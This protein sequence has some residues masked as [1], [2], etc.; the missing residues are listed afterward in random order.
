MLT[1]LLGAR[2]KHSAQTTVQQ[3]KS[4]RMLSNSPK[5]RQKSMQRITG[6]VLLFIGS[7]VILV[8]VLSVNME[9]A[10]IRFLP[11]YICRFLMRRG[12]I[13]ILI[14]C[15]FLGQDHVKE[16]FRYV[17]VGSLDDPEALSP[18]GEFFCQT[19]VSWMP[20]IPSKLFSL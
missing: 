13:S 2:R 16:Q 18:K 11:T 17:V 8:A 19:R 6:Q 15:S 4:P 3:P 9:Y 7:F 20:E 14:V 10:S 5:V 12:D 1:Y